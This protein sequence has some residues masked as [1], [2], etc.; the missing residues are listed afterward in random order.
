MNYCF[1]A[2]DP[3]RCWGLMQVLENLVQR[4]MAGLAIGIMQSIAKAIWLLDRGAAFIF[5]K[6]VPDN[7]WLLGLKD[8]M[9]QMFA[10]MMPGLLRQVAFGGQGLMYVA[11]SLAGLVMIVPLWGMGAR[12]VRPERVMVWGVLLSVLFVSGAF[13]YDLVGAV[14]GFRQGLVNQVVQGGA[15][16]PL[17]K[18]ILQPMQAGDGDLGFGMDILAL[19]PVYESNYFPAP[20]L[21]EVTISEGGGF[22]FG[23][24]LVETPDA[25][26]GRVAAAGRGVFY[27]LVSSFGAW[28]LLVVGVTY[29]IL[30]FAALV[31]ILFLFA[32]LPLGFFEFGEVILSGILERYFQLTVHSLALAVFLR[33]LSAGLGFIVDVNTVTN[34]LLWV[35][36][37][38]VMI[39]VAG[40]F[41]NGAVRIM[42]G[43]GGVFRTVQQSFGGPS[44][45]GRLRQAVGS[46]LAQAA[47]LVSLG[48]LVAG[49]P[50]IAAL[51]GAV[52]TGV[53]R[54]AGLTSL[55]PDDRPDGWNGRGNVFVD[56][57]NGSGRE[58]TAAVAPDGGR[59]A[60]GGSSDDL[61]R[62][63]AGASAAAGSRQAPAAGKGT[64]Q[65]D[66]GRRLPPRDDWEP[67]A[68]GGASGAAASQSSGQSA[69]PTVPPPASGAP[70]QQTAGSSDELRRA[71]EAAQ[72]MRGRR[73]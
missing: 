2:Y 31:L 71:V 1:P 21:T 16:M 49:R 38:V 53:R 54:Q 19:P 33:W 45:E 44:V 61:R 43:S 37:L 13:G 70:Q 50:E 23:N 7:G 20:Q 68:G 59:P 17:D 28:L 39:I 66:A 57:G 22:G 56:N 73:N 26:A 46:G 64:P 25:L 65:G 47:G 30:A 69:G 32:A 60:A 6:S 14:E 11:L 9:L 34:A 8:Q 36:V 67:Q 18:L 63:A 55:L 51:A 24:A 4:L 41:F 40:T 62:A 10:G 58:P 29:V 3:L 5:S 27:A 42:L 72:Q 48:A 35:V 12:L 15:A 52:G